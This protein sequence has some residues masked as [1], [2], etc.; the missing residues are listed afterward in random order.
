MTHATADCHDDKPRPTD[1]AFA[2]R[3][4]QHVRLEVEHRR[5]LAGAAPMWLV[6]YEALKDVWHGLLDHGE[7][8]FDESVVQWFYDMCGKFRDLGEKLESK[9]RAHDEHEIETIGGKPMSLDDLNACVEELSAIVGARQPSTTD[10]EAGAL[11]S[12]FS[13]E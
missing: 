12:F 2:R 4:I 1:V 9:L 8:S 11:R 3:L 7:E 5:Q 10:E 13:N 6:G